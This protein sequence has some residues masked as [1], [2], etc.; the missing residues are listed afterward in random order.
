MRTT[1]KDSH[2]VVTIDGTAV[3]ERLP[4]L[5]RADGGLNLDLIH[6][7][8]YRP[9]R[10]ITHETGTLTEIARTTWD[11]IDVPIAQIHITQTFPD[12]IVAWGVHLQQVDRLFVASGAVRFVC[13]DA[14]RDSPTH[15]LVNEIYVSDH[16]PALLVIPTGIYH[17]WKNIGGTESIIVRMPSE[18]YNFEFP[19]T[20]QLRWD[21]AAT[22]KI[23]PYYW[24]LRVRGF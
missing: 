4:S 12:G 23:I 16:Q 9:V 5:V 19:D 17:G 2:R 22:R 3:A 1:D 7:V 15:G 10:P 13:Y 14:R 18:N 21:D 24:S 6:G 20:L 8:R 11:E